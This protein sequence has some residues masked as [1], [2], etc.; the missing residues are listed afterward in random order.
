M[1]D[2][3]VYCAADPPLRPDWPLMKTP[4]AKDVNEELRFL[5]MTFSIV[6]VMV[7]VMDKDMK[8]ELR[9]LMMTLSS[10]PL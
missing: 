1:L 10:Y 4:M 2:E 9:C 5:M 6:M 3:S 7:M 8:E